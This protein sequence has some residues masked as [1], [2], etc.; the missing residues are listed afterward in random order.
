MALFYW[1]TGIVLAGIWL[2]R[3]IDAAIGMR[4]VPDIAATNWAPEREF[5][6]HAPRV[7]IVVPAKNEAEEIETC[8][9]SLLA[10]DYPDYEIVAVDDR[11]SDQTGAIMDR[12]ASGGQRLRIVHI[13]ELPDGWLGKTHA[14]WK[15]ANESRG[16]WILF[17]DGDIRFRQDALARAI[18][19]A[20]KIDTDMLVVFPTMIME[21]AG[22]RMMLSFF[23]SM[24]VFAHRPWKVQDPKS[25]DYMGV[26][27][28]NLIRRPVYEKVGT[29]S[30]LKL[31][32]LDDM[33]LARLA[34]EGGFKQRNVFGDGLIRLRWATS[35]IGVVQN[36]TKNLFALTGFRLS[37]AVGGALALT[38]VNAWPFLGVVLAPGWQKLGFGIAVAGIAVLYVGMGRVSKIS[39][40][41]FLTH[42]LASLIFSGA[43]LHSAGSAILRRGVV[44]RG[45]TYSLAELRK[46]TSR[47]KG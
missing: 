43:M 23:Q 34:K 29:Y 33:E 28:F 44:W 46:Q 11:S 40:L 1:I 4:D 36:L 35:A 32:I 41:Y 5:Y 3:L 12:L 17:T 45:T 31:S 16:D 21:T 10:L 42:P 14:M 47:P 9:Q 22:E 24:F 26:G 18:A 20:E 15:A 8:L 6:E 39:P 25:K 13:T 38:F 7:T 2:S 19:Y 30:A 27:A 37:V